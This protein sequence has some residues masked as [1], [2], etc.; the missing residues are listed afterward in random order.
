MRFAFV[1]LFIQIGDNN[2][3][4]LPTDLPKRK[5]ERI[6]GAAGRWGKFMLFGGCVFV[7]SIKRLIMFGVVWGFISMVPETEN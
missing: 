2:R 4:I 6:D 7:R 1:R 5:E 3:D